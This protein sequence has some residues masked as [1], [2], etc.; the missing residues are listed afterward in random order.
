MENRQS[1]MQMDDEDEDY[2]EEE[3]NDQFDPR[4]DQKIQ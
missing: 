1:N 3:A 4:L 2:D